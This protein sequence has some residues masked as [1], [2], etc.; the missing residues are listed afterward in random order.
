VVFTVGLTT[1]T[2]SYTVTMLGKVDSYEVELDSGQQKAVEEVLTDVDKDGGSWKLVNNPSSTTTEITDSI[3]I[4]QSQFTKATSDESYPVTGADADG[5]KASVTLSVDGYKDDNGSSSG[6]D[7]EEIGVTVSVS[8]GRLGVGSTT[9]V[10]N[11]TTNSNANSYDE[12]L[13][14]S[15]DISGDSESTVTGARTAGAKTYDFDDTD[16]DTSVS[17][18][19]V[20]TAPGVATI[21]KITTE[22]TTEEG[23]AEWTDTWDKTTTTTS[24]YNVNSISVKVDQL[25]TGEVVEYG[26]SLNSGA[27]SVDGTVSGSGADTD[28]TIRT[29]TVATDGDGDGTAYLE[30][31]STDDFRVLTD[32]VTVN[33]DYDKTVD[34]DTYAQNME[35]DVTRT[36]TTE[37]TTVVNSHD[38]TLVFHLDGQDGDGDAVS[39]QFLV[40]LDTNNDG[41]LTSV[42]QT[43]AVQETLAD[44]GIFPAIEGSSGY[45]DNDIMVG[46]EGD[47]TISGG[48]GDDTIYGGAGEDTID[49]GKGDDTLFGGS[50]TDKVTGGDGADTF[51]QSE[52]TSGE[53][54]DYNSGVDLTPLVSNPDDQTT[55]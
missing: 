16:T 41:V 10:G 40:T 35:A 44:N 54:L 24:D 39:T 7:T 36:T 30:A 51:S 34:T 9:E 2:S 27:L 48:T 50:G 6:Y 19:S 28:T 21:T 38:I 15:A 55:T 14:L 26:D 53:V 11:D 46:S 17:S 52:V 4:A 25:G 18:S 32:G 42:D 31:Q 43:P 8:D 49:G 12:R 37:T 45:T 23:N 13:K 1:A 33:Y 47:D 3:T 5:G 22:I 20:T 29:V